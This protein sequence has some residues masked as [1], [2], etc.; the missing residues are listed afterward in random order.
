MANEIDTVPGCHRFAFLLLLLLH[1]Q[2]SSALLLS[3]CNICLDNHVLSALALTTID[4]VTDFLW[5]AESR[6]HTS[7]LGYNRQELIKKRLF[8]VTATVVVAAEVERKK[9]PNEQT[10]DAPRQN[11]PP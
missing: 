5:S 4:T 6:T 2:L 9:E 7:L 10:N 8:T 11:G 3:A 1:S